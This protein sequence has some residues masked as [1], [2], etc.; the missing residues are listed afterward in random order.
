MAIL[1]YYFLF[2]QEF[3]FT[4]QV[5]NVF[6]YYDNKSGNWLGLAGQVNEMA[7]GWSEDWWSENLK[8]EYT[9]RPNCLKYTQRQNIH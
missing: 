9:T 4:T 1:D 2:F 8:A 6:S 7:L 3:N 5:V